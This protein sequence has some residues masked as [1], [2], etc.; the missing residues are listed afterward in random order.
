[1]EQWIVADPTDPTQT[2][3]ASKTCL[4]PMV[5]PTTWSMLRLH[6]FWQNAILL[7]P[8]G[9]MDQPARYLEAM[10]LIDEALKYDG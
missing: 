9:L 3:I 10:Q 4:L 5:E 6:R 8:G 2:I 7:R 1:M